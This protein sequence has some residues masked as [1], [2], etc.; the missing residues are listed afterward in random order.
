MEEEGGEPTK[1]EAEVKGEEAADER[2]TLLVLGLIALV[3]AC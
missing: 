3:E 2:S 1:A